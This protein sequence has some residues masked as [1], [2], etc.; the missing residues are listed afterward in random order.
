METHFVIKQLRANTVHYSYLNHSPTNGL[1]GS[2]KAVLLSSIA[3]HGFAMLLET[4]AF[5]DLFR[6]AS[7]SVTHN[8]ENEHF[9]DQLYYRYGKLPVCN[10]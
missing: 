1:S 5:F 7:F 4:A 3:L 6:C 9:T 2:D 10:L 8:V